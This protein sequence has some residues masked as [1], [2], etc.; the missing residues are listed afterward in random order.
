MPTVCVWER[1]AR[2]SSLWAHSMSYHVLDVHWVGVTVTKDI[3]SPRL[4]VKSSGR[5][6]CSSRLALAELDCKP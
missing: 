1:L 5:V 4:G 2:P 3:V 6:Y